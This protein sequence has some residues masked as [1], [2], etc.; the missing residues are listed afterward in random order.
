MTKRHPLTADYFREFEDCYQAKP[1]KE[2]ER[3]RRF[4]RNEIDGRD[5]N[6]DIFWL[7]DE[8]LGDAGDLPEPEDLVSEAVTQLETA[9]DALNELALILD[10]NGNNRRELA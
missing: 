5:D 9:L 10:R 2:S 6:M 8:S 1:R 3:F 4:A 7:K